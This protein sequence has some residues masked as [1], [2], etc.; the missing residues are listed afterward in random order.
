MR[1]SKTIAFSILVTLAAL[2]VAFVATRNTQGYNAADK[3]TLKVLRKKD[4]LDL[5]PTAQEIAAQLPQV[6]RELVDNLPKHLPLKIKVKNLSNEKWVRD[7]AVEVENKS[8]KP[9]YYLHI[10]VSL[11]DVK[12]ENGNNMGFSLRYGRG[13]LISFAV[14]VESDDVPIKP[15]ESYTLK[16]PE[17]HQLGWERFVKRRGL[18]KSEPKKIKFIFQYLNFG[19]G[20]GFRF[21]SG[22][23]FD[24]HKRRREMMRREPE[25]MNSTTPSDELPGRLS[26]AMLNPCSL[27]P[28]DV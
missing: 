1:H 5:K 3:K 9:I 20:T 12:S 16:I 8:D 26:T 23:P 28:A 25:R 11:P 24:I 4:H 14:P 6:E 19:D 15:G 18:S 10:V 22:I 17:Q 27:Q 21:P 13:A 7:F 2:G